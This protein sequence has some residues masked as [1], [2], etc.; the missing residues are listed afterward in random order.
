M[1]EVAPHEYKEAP[2]ACADCG[3]SPVNHLETY[4]SHSLGMIFAADSDPRERGK[5]VGAIDRLVVALDPLVYR[6]FAAL[7]GARFAHD[8]VK[9]ATYRSQVIWEE[10]RRRGIEMEQL[11]LIGKH[12]DIYRAR[13]DGAWRYFQS[14]PVPPQLEYPSYGWIDDKIALKR[15]LAS[16]GI[17]VPRFASVSTLSDA[18][19]AFA[20]IGAPAVVKP[21]AGS[22][23]RHTTVNVRELEELERAFES[24]QK[25]CRYVAIEEY[26]EGS[27]C[28]GTVIGGKLAGFFEARAPRVVGDGLSSIE[29]LIQKAN[30]TRP[31]RVQDIVLTDESLRFLARSGRTPD[32]VPALGEIVPLSHRTGRLF[33]GYTR[34]LFGKEHGKL[35]Q[36]LERAAK[37]VGAPVVGFDLIIADPERDPDGQK[38]GII[39]GNSLPYIDL[40]YLPLEGTPSNT[41]AAVW[42][43]WERA[44]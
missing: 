7:P 44:L 5:I 14:L 19:D 17:D 40:H 35:R 26:I 25:L 23:G 8:P 13:I 29:V 34:E 41:A 27:V 31:E 9:S 20:A 11:V 18:R 15:A 16:A 38:W 1:T 12:T 32:F 4:L 2:G 6:F 39:E 28:R 22:R 3:N 10:A 42:D 43:L 33:G 30:H 24:A 21:R 37:A 36:Y